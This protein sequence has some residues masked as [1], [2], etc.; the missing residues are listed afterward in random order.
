MA[1]SG[2]TDRGV[3]PPLPLEAMRVLDVTRVMAPQQIRR[4]PPLLG[5]GAPTDPSAASA[6]GGAQ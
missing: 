2:E 3:A 1:D 4:R 6:A 5:E